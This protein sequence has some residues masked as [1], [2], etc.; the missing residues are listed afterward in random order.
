MDSD[1]VSSNTA[2]AREAGSNEQ[3][4]DFFLA[5]DG[6]DLAQAEAL[7]DALKARRYRVFLD[8]MCVKFGDRWDVVIPAAQRVSRATVALIP[9]APGPEYYKSEEIAAAIDLARIEGAQHRVVPVYLKGPRVPSDTPYGLRRLRSVFVEIEGGM[10]GVAERLAEVVPSP[11][12][13][14]QGDASEEITRSASELNRL[15]EARAHRLAEGKPIDELNTK[16][17]DIKRGLRGHGGRIQPGDVLDHRYQIKERLGDGGFATVWKAYDTRE[18]AFVAVKVLH[19]HRAADRS[20]VERFCRG[21]RCMH[22]LSHPRIVRVREHGCREGGFHFFVMDYLA[23]GNLRDAVLAKRISRDQALPTILKLGEALQCAHDSGLVHRDVKPANILLDRA[24]QPHLTD[25]DLVRAADSTGGTKTSALG[26]FVYAAPE[27][28]ERGQDADARSDVFSLAMTTAFGLYGNDLPIRAFRATERFMAELT[29]HPG[30]RAVL[31][32]AVESAPEQRYATVTAFCSALRDAASATI[33]D[34]DP[35][36]RPADIELSKPDSGRAGGTVLQDRVAGW[37]RTVNRRRAL[38][39]TLLLAAGAIAFG[40]IV[41]SPT[42]PT[43]ATHSGP[44]A[45]PDIGTGPRKEDVTA[46]P[47]AGVAGTAFGLTV[48]SPTRPTVATHSGRAAEPDIG[49][50]ARKEDVTASPDAGVAATRDE[51]LLGAASSI[52]WAHIK[53][54]TFLMGST[55]GDDDERPV[56]KVTLTEFWMSKT[57]IT[58]GQYRACVAE[59]KCTE[60]RSGG[61]CTWAADANGNLPVNCVDWNQART[62]AQWVGGDLPT[63]AQWEYACRAG[64]TTR[65]WSGDTEKALGN[66]GWYGKNSGNRVHV[67][68]EKPAS[69]WGL[70]DMHGNLWE[71]C[72]DLYGPYAEGEQSDP[73]GP[74]EGS[75]GGST[76][77]LR[78]GS[79]WDVAVWAR[80]AFRSRLDPSYRFFGIGFRVVRPAAPSSRF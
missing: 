13:H 28:M 31:L 44:T 26:S 4:Y 35:R 80:S 46:S 10:L 2:P 79:R 64:T 24:D 56:H 27:A 36:R 61:M 78:G 40:L 7:F 45:D 50:G 6:P 29:C 43:V 59:G 37:I 42:R 54:G 65:Y 5:H 17:A 62:F 68:G 32:K 73:T 66:V 69:P 71:W 55:E 14:G 76:R 70:H 72:R 41:T 22:E 75:R 33:R 60:P 1:H 67:V 25:F 20:A 9:A 53:G 48:T 34:R 38:L 12:G 3:R 47:D 16:I 49:T 18:K 21:A 74:A 52:D 19:A 8:S 30:V 57:E 23:G 15:E 11:I 51:E 63:E 77:V 39:V 58:V